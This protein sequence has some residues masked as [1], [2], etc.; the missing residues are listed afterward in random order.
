M[1]AAGR[2]EDEEG[3]QDSSCGP[4]VTSGDGIDERLRAARGH[5][6]A[7]RCF[8]LVQPGVK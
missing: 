7:A 1:A 3:P 4:S 8:D 6:N 2:D 5:G